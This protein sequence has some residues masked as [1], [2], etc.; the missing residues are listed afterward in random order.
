MVGKRATAILRKATRRLVQL[1][2]S[3]RDEQSIAEA[4]IVAMVFSQEDCMIK[5]VRGDLNFVNR[6]NQRL[7][8]MHQL[9]RHFQKDAKVL[10]Q[11]WGV[12]HIDSVMGMIGI[13]PDMTPSTEMSMRGIRV[14]KMGVDEYSST[15]RVVVSIDRFLRVRDQRGNVLLSP[16]EVSETQGTERLTITYSSSMMWE[17]NGPESVLVNTYQWI[18]RNWEAVKIQWSQNPAMLYNKMEFEP[19]QSLVPKA[20]RR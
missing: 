11:N 9:L 12:E 5:A 7:N 1:I 2:V 14:S 13:L 10:F 19:F 16:E 4:I 18:I 8:P 17:I 15:E 20:I 3:G 6:A